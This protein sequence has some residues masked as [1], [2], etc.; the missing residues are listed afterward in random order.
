M[1]SKDVSQLSIKGLAVY[2]PLQVLWIQKRLYKNTQ[3]RV[4]IEDVCQRR[5]LASWVREHDRLR[6]LDMLSLLG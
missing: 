1:R 5:T 6:N 3:V 2:N 4:Y